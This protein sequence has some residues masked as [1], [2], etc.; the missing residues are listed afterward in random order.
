MM[1]PLPQTHSCLLFKF[2]LQ[3]SLLEILVWV[4]LL[5]VMRDVFFSPVCCGAAA[6]HRDYGDKPLKSEFV[7][8]ALFRIL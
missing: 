4:T 1:A 6:S 8:E 3:T 5:L 2:Y 7:S